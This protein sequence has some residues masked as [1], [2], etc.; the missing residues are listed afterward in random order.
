MA[1]GEIARNG[2]LP[3]PYGGT[4]QQNDAANG[5]EDTIDDKTVKSA[6]TEGQ[7]T[8]SL[9]VNKLVSKLQS[10]KVVSKVGNNLYYIQYKNN[11]EMT[12]INMVLIKTA[13]LL[14]DS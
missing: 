11:Q 1:I 8:K 6:N 14:R 9:L 3:L 7:L 5:L 4:I 13:I 12:Y 10:S 2:A